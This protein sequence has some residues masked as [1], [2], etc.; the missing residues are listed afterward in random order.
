M[1]SIDLV[2]DIIEFPF[3]VGSIHCKLL[4]QRVL[5][6]INYEL[7]TNNRFV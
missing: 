5:E 6:A 7:F 2:K 4:L 3:V 1:N